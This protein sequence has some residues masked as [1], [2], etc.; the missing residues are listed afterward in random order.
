MIATLPVKNATTFI[1]ENGLNLL[2][3][4]PFHH[5]IG[6]R[7][8]GNAVN[9]LEHIS[10]LNT[11]RILYWGDIDVDGFLILSRL[12]NLFPHVESIMMDRD[13]L[14][15]HDA[16]VVNGNDSALAV[17]TNL[18]TSET[19]TFD[20]CSHNNC[21]LEQEKIL[22]PFVNQRLA[23]LAARLRSLRIHNRGVSLDLQN[24][25]ESLVAISIEVGTAILFA[26]GV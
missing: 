25:D 5:G 6:I 14:E 18:T 3:L 16:Y 9:R 8:E 23:T 12:R 15:H 11:N 26:I 10:W 7:G 20:F 19:A 13:T 22:Q 4:P 24:R 21:R 1:V 2:T 17:P